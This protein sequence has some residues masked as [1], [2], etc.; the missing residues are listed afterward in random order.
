MPVVLHID[1]AG[2]GARADGSTEGRNE[3]TEIARSRRKYATNGITG[4]NLIPRVS[5]QRV[6]GVD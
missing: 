4:G 1:F 2:S 5:R 6:A 3:R